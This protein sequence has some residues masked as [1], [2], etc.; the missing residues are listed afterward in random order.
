[1]ILDPIMIY[2]LLGFPEM[3][4]DGAALATVIGQLVS[5]ALAVIFHLKKNTELSNGLRYLKPDMS[6]VHDIYAIGLPARENP[7][8]L[9]LVWLTFLIA[10]GISCLISVLFMRRIRRRKFD[11]GQTG[12]VCP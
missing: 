7:D 11:A 12:A 8:Q 1:M 10:E 2:G 4:V 5:L 3:G 6:V 9:W